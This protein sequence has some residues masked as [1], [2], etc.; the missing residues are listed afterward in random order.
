MVGTV[1]ARHHTHLT[2]CGAVVEGERGAGQPQAENQ[3]TAE[4]EA[5]D[6]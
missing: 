5:G 6:Q 2:L 1:S 4:A 3:Y